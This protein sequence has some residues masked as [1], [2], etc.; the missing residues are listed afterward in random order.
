MANLA[1]SKRLLG[2]P[3]FDHCSYGFR[4]CSATFKTNI[5]NFYIC[6][7]TFVAGDR[8][9]IASVQ[10]RTKSKLLCKALI[11]L[12]ISVRRHQSAGQ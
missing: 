1:A 7:E 2:S 3:F 4:L 6:E 11:K 10:L 5:F 8:N 9:R 12:H